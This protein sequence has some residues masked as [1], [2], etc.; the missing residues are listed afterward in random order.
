VLRLVCGSVL[1]GILVA[2]LW[3]FHTPMNDVT[4]LN[5][6]NGLLFGRHGVMLSSESNDL[7][8]LEG[9]SYRSIEIWLQP[10]FIDTGGTILAFYSP[11]SRTGTFSLHQSLDDLL[12][13][14]VNADWKRRVR[15]KWYIEHVFRKDKQVI[16]TITVSP[17]STMVYVN[18]APVGTSAQFGLSIQDLTGQLVVGNRPLVDNGWQGQ[19]RGL[20]VY[21][22]ELNAAEVSQHYADWKTSQG[23]KIKNEGAAALYLCNEGLGAV[24]HDQM[25]PA[26][27]LHIPDR[28]FV[29]DAPLLELPWDEFEFSWSYCKDV[30]INIGGFVPLGFFFCAYFSQV[31]RLDRSV[32][33]TT[34]LGSVVSC[35]IEVLQAFLPTRNSGMTDIVTNTLGTTL[36]AMLYGCQLIRG[37]F[38][39][40]LGFTKFAPPSGDHREKRPSSNGTL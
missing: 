20:A 39:T 10:A 40:V 13:R 27:D 33:A 21:N 26:N 25:N 11:A 35:A 16:V 9:G 34:V 2:G 30:L 5:D 4:W 28:Y 6:G 17:Q 3:P 36:G 32:L 37:L 15:T 1:A 7:A 22:R 18:G 24:V 38:A 8:G 12:L 19:L 14:R 23:A 29:L 31:R